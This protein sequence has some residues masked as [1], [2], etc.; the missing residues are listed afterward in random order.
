MHPIPQAPQPQPVSGQEPGGGLRS[1]KLFI[2]ALRCGRLANRISL[3][4]NFIALAEDQ[5]HRLINFTFHSYAHLFES[6]RRDVYCQY[7]PPARRSWLDVLPGV[8]PALRKTR[9]LYHIVRAAGVL[10]ERFPV[11]GRRVVTIRERPRQNVTAL[12]GPEVQEPIAEA[13]VVF[14]HGFHFRAPHWLERHAEKIRAYFRPIELHAR[15]SRH[16][17]ER[18]RHNADVVVGVHIRRDRKRHV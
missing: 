11:L 1:G 3:F 14:V 16:A 18:L 17:V 6:T 8:A 10:N 13:K 4:A 12:E 7:P 2:I 5:G 9:L 15:A